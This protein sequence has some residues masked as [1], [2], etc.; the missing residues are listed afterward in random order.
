MN[1][2]ALSAGNMR[3][4]AAETN[5]NFRNY[6]FQLFATFLFTGCRV[7]VS[8]HEVARTFSNI[9]SILSNILNLALFSFHKIVALNAATTSTQAPLCSQLYMHLN[10][11]FGQFLPLNSKEVA[12]SSPE[13]NKRTH[14]DALY[15]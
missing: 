11:K 15:N 12:T 9:C 10:S 3:P 8:F 13:V 6:S 7:E 4:G 14:L 5:Y 1:K 2:L